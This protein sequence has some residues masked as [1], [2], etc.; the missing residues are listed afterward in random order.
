MKRG[1]AGGFPTA[2]RA[3]GG[4]RASVQIDPAALMKRHVL[5]ELQWQG[6]GGTFHHIA[7]TSRDVRRVLWTSSGMVLLLALAIVS[8]FFAVLNRAPGPHGIEAVL[9]E[10]MELK[11]RQEVLRERVFDLAD[12]L[13]W[14][15][16]EER[17]MAR[18]ADTAGPTRVAECPPPPARDAG[19]ET[20]LAWLSEQGTRLE[21]LGNTLTASRVEMR[22]QQASAPAT[23]NGNRVS[24]RGEPARRPAGLEPAKRHAAA[25][26]TR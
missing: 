11:A 8:G 12:Q 1:E 9:R 16:D 17:R 19:D 15:F 7:L 2:C 3:E 13:Y 25:A 21:A 26:A 23:V 6:R 24:A 4:P 10:N 5:V 20:L 14:H 22:A 18:L